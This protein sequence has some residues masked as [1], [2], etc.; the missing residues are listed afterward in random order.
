MNIRG[1]TLIRPWPWAIF[2][3][4]KDVENRGWK[5]SASQLKPGDWIA[6]HAGGKW[7]AAG[8]SSIAYLFDVKVPKAEQ[9]PSAVIVGLVR[10]SGFVTKSASTWFSGHYGWQWDRTIELAEPVQH[11]GAMGLWKLN[12][13]AYAQCRKA[14]EA[15][16]AKDPASP[17]ACR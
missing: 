10:Y 8:A 3:A 11:K 6:I 12:D 9:H 5:P 13:E 7:D 1:L 16:P 4:G 2:K 17:G 14:I 15:N